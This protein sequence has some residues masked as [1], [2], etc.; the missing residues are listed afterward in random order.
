MLKF[1]KY[2]LVLIIFSFCVIFLGEKVDYDLV[3]STWGSKSEIEIV[4]SLISDF[5][6][7]NNVK[8]KL[9][10]VPQNYFQ[11]LQ[12]LFASKK[13]PD[14]LFVNNYYLPVYYNAGLLLDLSPYFKEEVKQGL[15]FENALKSMS[16]DDRIYAV[17]RDISNLVVFYNKNLFVK[18]GVTFPSENWTYDDFLKISKKL[19]NNAHWAVSFE[20]NPLYWQPV[21]WSNC[22]TVFDENKQFVLNSRKALESLNYYLSLRNLYKVSPDKANTANRTMAQLF[23]DE[24]IAMHISGRWLV[25]KYRSEAKFD[26][27]VVSL[28]NG[29]C[30]SIVGSDSSGWAVSQDTK[31][32]QLAV[33]FVKFLSSK[34]SLK[35]ITASGLI[36]PA[37]RDV[38]YSDYFLDNKA[39]KNSKIFLKINNGAK[40]N[41]IPENYNQKIE[42][43]MKVLEPY[44]LGIKK[45]TPNTQF[46]L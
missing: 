42:K 21:L 6:I 16:F 40:I 33:E 32:V 43:L 18:N 38:A 46:E 3:F 7:K 41:I 22:S 4:K 10:H 35:E 23:L 39:P 12:L 36:T 34:N 45:I 44:F 20:E 19:T 1:V 29:K 2:L 9:V 25:P 37:R 15:F 13:A 8:V 14:V 28:P 30:G 24:K 26:W 5:E 27:D 31:N 11:K 17:P